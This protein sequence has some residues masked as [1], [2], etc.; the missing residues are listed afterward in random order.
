MAEKSKGSHSLTYDEILDGLKFYLNNNYQEGGPVDLEK[1]RQLKKIN[2]WQKSQGLKSIDMSDFEKAQA[3]NE[4][5]TS[6]PSGLSSILRKLGSRIPAVALLGLLSDTIPS[7]EQF[8]ENLK[9][10]KE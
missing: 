3:N 9:K 2:E 1:Y 7:K 8:E 6:S 4:V 5:K 10:L